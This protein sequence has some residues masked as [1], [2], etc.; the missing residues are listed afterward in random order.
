M[1]VFDMNSS[2]DQ[3]EFHVLAA[4]STRRKSPTFDARD[5]VP[6][7]VLVIVDDVVNTG[8][9]HDAT[10]STDGHSGASERPIVHG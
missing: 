10:F 8:F 4:L 1:M 2:F 7:C 6:L 5:L 9:G 3:T